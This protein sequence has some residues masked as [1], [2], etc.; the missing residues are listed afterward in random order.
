MIPSTE[1]TLGNSLFRSFEKW[2]RLFPC[3]TCGKNRL[4]FI[5]TESIKNP[6]ICVNCET[7]FT[8]TQI[9]RGK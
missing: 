8:L 3:P 2:Q 7:Q 5:I 9:I 4:D 1:I 6:I